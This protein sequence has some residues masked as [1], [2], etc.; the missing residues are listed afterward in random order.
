MEKVASF[1]IHHAILCNNC[2]WP[3]FSESRLYEIRTLSQSLGITLELGI[4]E[5]DP[6]AYRKALRG[7]QILGASVVR[8][9]YDL[10]RS[11]D[12]QED[13]A[14]LASMRRCFAEILPDAEAAG[15]T[16][17]I[18][19][20]PI[21]SNQEIAALIEDVRSPNFGAC[22]DTMNCV[23][24]VCRPEE[25]FQSLAKYARMVHFKDYAIVPNKRG[26]IIQGTALG[27]GCVDFP[28]MLQYLKDAGYRGNVYLELY[29]DRK[30]TEEETF[31]Y[32]EACVRRSV[33]YARKL[34][35]L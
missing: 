27:D 10:E 11:K 14:E 1:G 30:E 18:E 16:L 6:E 8:V 31:A 21:L 5:T 23:Y 20:G 25:V 4:R 12:P 9:V 17:A 22:L 2:E 35:L 34:G 29:I 24:A 28:N 13:S 26:Y 19:N 32:E 15:V 3:G 7:A 33:D